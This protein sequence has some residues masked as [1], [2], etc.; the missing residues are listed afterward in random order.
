MISIKCIEYIEKDLEKSLNRNI[1]DP[2]KKIVGKLADNVR[3]YLLKL[4][5]ALMIKET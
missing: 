3:M 2:L 1:H 4:I 5:M